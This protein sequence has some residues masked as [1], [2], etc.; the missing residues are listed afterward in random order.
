MS[1]KYE[2][3]PRVKPIRLHSAEMLQANPTLIGGLG[4]VVGL[5]AQTVNALLPV[6]ETA[7][8]ALLVPSLLGGFVAGVLGSVRLGRRI[9]RRYYERRANP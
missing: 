4:V 7:H 6:S 8:S 2:G 9:E 3:L 1:N 5:L